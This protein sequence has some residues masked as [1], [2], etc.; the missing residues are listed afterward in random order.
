MIT[1]IL[2]TALIIAACYVYLRHQRQKQIGTSAQ[3]KSAT[4]VTNKNTVTSQFK[5]LAISLVVL[6]ACAAIG[7][8][9]YNLMDDRRVLNV[10]ITNPH[11]SEVVTYQ[12]YKGDM[13]ERSFETLQGQQVRI[14]SSE[15]IE[16]SEAP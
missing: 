6:T 1:K 11:N 12:V 7:F 5:W 10:K 4:A 9:I 15:R 14:S 16:I 13:Q 3:T 8:F 2:V